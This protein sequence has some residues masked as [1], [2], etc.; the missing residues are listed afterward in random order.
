MVEAGDDLECTSLCHILL[1]RQAE[2]LVGDWSPN[3]SKS[4]R[5]QGD[6]VCHA[7]MPLYLLLCLL[8]STIC[9]IYPCAF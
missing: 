9:L 5:G 2:K 7:A 4:S 1:K 3:R 6:T 8:Y